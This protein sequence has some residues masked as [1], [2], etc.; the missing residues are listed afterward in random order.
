MT[1]LDQA[2]SRVTYEI[3]DGSNNL[4]NQKIVTSVTMAAD[5]IWYGFKFNNKG[6]TTMSKLNVYNGLKASNEV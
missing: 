1:K 5:S 4:T 2:G 3:Y 6:T